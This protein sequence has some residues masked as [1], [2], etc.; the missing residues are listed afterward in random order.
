LTLIVDGP[1]LRGLTHDDS[2]PDG[3]WERRE[4][5]PSDIL[6]QDAFE[7]LLPE[8]M[9]LDFTLLSMLCGADFLRHTILVRAE[10]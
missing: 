6:R 1:G 8:L 9:R 3:R 7:N 2:Q 10:M 4:R 5:F